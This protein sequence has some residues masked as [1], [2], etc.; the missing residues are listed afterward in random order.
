MSKRIVE[1]P[2]PKAGDLVGPNYWRSLDDRAES[3]EFRT[4]VEKEFPAGAAELDG[5]NRRH[6]LKI[7][8]ASFGLA[9]LGLA[10]C[11]EPRNYTLPYAKQPENLVPG[12]PV[13]FATSFPGSRSHQPLIV[14]THQYRP[15]KI[16]G[17]TSYGLNGTATSKYAQASILDLYDVD[18]ATASQDGTGKTLDDAKVADILAG[19]AAEA[20]AANGAGYAFLAQPS[21]SPSR[22]RLVAGLKAKLPAAI[23]AEYEPVAQGVADRAVSQLAGQ[24]VRLRPDFA[25]AKRVLSLD[26][27]FLQSGDDWV[28][29]AKAFAAARRVDDPKEVVAQMN[30]LY[31]VESTFTLTGAQAD[32]RLRVAAS[33][34]P[35]FTALLVAEVLAQTGGDSEL[36]D[37]LKSK[38]TGVLADAN[39]IKESVAD[40]VANKGAALIVAGDHLPESVHAIVALANERLSA[41]GHTL[42]YVST[43]DTAAA[44]ITDLAEAIEGGKVQTLVVLGGNPAYDAPADLGSKQQ[45]FAKL[46]AG[47][48]VVRHGYHGPKFDE[49][50]ALTAKNGGVFLASTHYLESWNDGRAADG[51]YVPVQPMI[52]PLFSGIDELA[53]LAPFAAVKA[54]AYAIVK[55]TFAALGGTNFDAWLAEGVLAGTVYQAASVKLAPGKVKALVDEADFSGAVL[56]YKSAADQNLEVRVVASSHAFDGRY[57]NNGWLAETPD[58][59]LKTNWENVIA[60]SPKLANTLNVEPEAMF[61]NSTLKGLNRNINQLV[62]GKLTCRV[63]TL[64][65]NGRTVTGP[66][67]ILPG[68]P[69]YTVSV[70]LGFG[71]RQVGRIGSRVREL[72]FENTIVGTGYDAYPFVTTTAPAYAAGVK[73]TLTGETAVVANTQDHWSMEGRDII[74]EANA[75]DYAHNPEFARQM[76]PES[77]S[78]KVYGAQDGLSAQ[79]KALKQPRGNSAYEHPAHGVPAPNVA[80]WKGHE[81]EFQAP[82]QW[83]M[84]IDLNTCTGCNACVVACQSENNIPIVGRDQ[85]IKGRDMRWIRLD[86]YFF[87]GRGKGDTLTI[88]E[89]PQVT[90]MSIACMHC[91]TAPCESVCPANATVHD[92]EGINTMAYNRCIGTRYCANNCPY[93]VRRFNFLD[94]SDK[95]IGH[96]YEGP[97][98]SQQSKPELQKM[99]MNPDVS[100]RMRGV[101]EKCTFC[102]QRISEAKIR[103][104]SDNKGSGDTKVA[105]GVIKTACQQVC[106]SEAIVFGDISDATTAV[107]KAKASKRDYGVLSFLNTRPRTTYLAK[108]RNPNP[109]MPNAPKSPLSKLEYDAKNGHGHSEHAA[110]GAHAEAGAHAAHPEGHSH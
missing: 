54:D 107:S 31:A 51:T 98:G 57:G 99:Q 77:H 90:F 42:V 29:A 66:L 13:Y 55:D 79:D 110:P 21:S 12:V 40:L 14:E 85:T 65:L 100:V 25:K 38:A 49:T 89:D 9:G 61:I 93:K 74:R 92:E 62:D 81:G 83:G 56:K 80:V 19:L 18:R 1:F 63:A 75:D 20:L 15:T 69:D 30:R 36:S 24:A 82:Q 91:E 104:K 11:R 6:F 105:D 84:S 37:S 87:D 94:Y 35:G 5:V 76:G 72:E 67:F 27:D 17:N 33:H 28:A 78:P 68:M 32:H 102:I 101:M 47:I 50:S 86:R 16:E 103:T 97:F 46:V 52:R 10:G 64:T 73:L 70:Q 26:A 4:W 58:P 3:P 96:F 44:S 88:P 8:G 7:M 23:W 2:Q 71:R 106:P 53:V 45:G 39:W 43:N 60:I 41:P 108:L 34:I 59:M 109:K 22:A 48:K 95:K